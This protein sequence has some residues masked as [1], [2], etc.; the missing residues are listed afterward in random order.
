[1]KFKEIFGKI[2]VTNPSRISAPTLDRKSGLQTP[3][4]Y[5]PLQCRMKLLSFIQA[6]P[7][8]NPAN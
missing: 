8:V 1:M 2:G 3:L 5:L 6:G 7:R 4:T